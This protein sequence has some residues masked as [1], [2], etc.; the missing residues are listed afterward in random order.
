M[1]QTP[2]V[3]RV[4]ARR[5]KPAGLTCV[6][7]GGLGISLSA[8]GDSR[9]TA[10]T[11][12][13]NDSSWSDD[14]DG[15]AGA[16]P[17]AAVWTYDT[18]NNNGW[19]NGELQ[20]YTANRENVHL[21]GQG[22][23]VIRVESSSDGYTSARLKTEGRRTVRFGRLEARIKIPAGAG[24]WPAFWMLGSS[25][26]G[27]NWPA[28]GEID[29]AE[30]KGHQPAIVHAAVHG[31]QYSGAAGITAPFALAGAS[32]AEDFHT[33]AVVREPQLIRF[34]VDGLPYHTVTAR[35]IPNGSEWVFEQPFFVL[36]NVAVGGNFVGT[37]DTGTQFPQQM[38]VDYVRYVSAN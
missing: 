32:F 26:D 33:F 12:V 38:L 13:E 21:D 23:L 20:R 35:D 5:A 3:W 29:V 18:G 16:P 30:F 8:C 14:F 10:P 27:F 36:L 4:W 37:P 25:F 19:G 34:V 17:N 9:A 28:C 31:P 7:V 24:I 1:E 2:G 11:R 22:H 6:L 15:P